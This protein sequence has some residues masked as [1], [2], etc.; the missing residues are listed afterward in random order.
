[1]T[2]IKPLKNVWVCVD[3]KGVPNLFTIRWYRKDSIKQLEGSG[4][5]WYWEDYKKAGWKCVKVNLEFEV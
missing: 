3:A 4:S 2:Q 5:R 1:M